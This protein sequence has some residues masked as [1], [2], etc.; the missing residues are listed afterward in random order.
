MTRPRF[1]TYVWTTLV[2]WREG[3]DET[4]RILYADTY[5]ITISNWHNADATM[6]KNWIVT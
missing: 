6:P 4:F 1:K 2:N 3:D 5:S